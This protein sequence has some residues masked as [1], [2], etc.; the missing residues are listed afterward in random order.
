LFYSLSCLARI[1]AVAQEELHSSLKKVRGEC[2]RIKKKLEESCEKGERLKVIAVE[3]VKVR[4]FN[5]HPLTLP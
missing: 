1:M 5:F 3:R 4:G 2:T